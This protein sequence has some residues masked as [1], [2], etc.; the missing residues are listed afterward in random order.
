MRPPLFVLR[1]GINHLLIGRHPLFG[2]DYLPAWPDHIHRPLDYGASQINRLIRPGNPLAGVRQQGK[3]IALLAAVVIMRRYRGGIDR[4]DVGPQ[5]AKY[6]LVRLKGGQLSVSPR[7]IVLGVKNQDSIFG[8][9]FRE[10]HAPPTRSI[11]RKIGRR[12]TDL[13]H[14]VSPVH[15][16][17]AVCPHPIML[18]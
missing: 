17:R 5:S 2:E 6:V 3:S 1:D 15:G 8:R 18:N 16:E 12:F 4:P 9:S 13:K 11:Q 7:S 14:I 10:P